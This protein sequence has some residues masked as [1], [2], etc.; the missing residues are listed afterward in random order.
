VQLQ[1]LCSGGGQRALSAEQP[2]ATTMIMPFERL[3]GLEEMGRKSAEWARMLK[4]DLAWYDGID[5]GIAGEATNQNSDNTSAADGATLLNTVQQLIEF[6]QLRDKIYAETDKAFVKGL[7]KT[8]G[9]MCADLEGP[10]GACLE[11]QE[12]KY[13][14]LQTRMRRIKV[15]LAK[16]DE[17]PL[18]LVNGGAGPDGGEAQEQPQQPHRALLNQ[19]SSP[20]APQPCSASGSQQRSTLDMAMQSFVDTFVVE[21]GGAASCLGAGIVDTVTSLRTMSTEDASVASE[22]LARGRTIT[23]EEAKQMEAAMLERQCSREGLQSRLV[24]EL[25]RAE[26]V[27]VGLAQAARSYLEGERARLCGEPET[28]RATEEALMREVGAVV[29]G[30]GGG[31]GAA[32]GMGVG[33]P[34]II[35]CKTGL[36]IVQDG[37]AEN[38][39]GLTVVVAMLRA[40]LALLRELPE[41]RAEATRQWRHVRRADKLA[42]KVVLSKQALQTRIDEA[43]AFAAFSSDSEGEDTEDDET[44]TADQEELQGLEGRLSSAIESTEQAMAMLASLRFVSTK[45]RRRGEGWGRGRRGGEG[46]HG[47]NDDV[48]CACACLC[49]S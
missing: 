16:L 47:M 15:A 36:Q 21:E 10:V 29:G 40:C 11:A 46:L 26:G 4:E 32:G 44:L 2:R 35:E 17:G 22:L 6:D 27:C 41:L 12:K 3:M 49:A 34:P 24:K 13:A 48:P 39:Q 9:Q 31:G 8:R 19:S 18:Q 23:M 7:A 5:A 38:A 1:R 25:S 43:R 37:R 20:A 45:P 28:A 42:A 30:E 14:V 33:P